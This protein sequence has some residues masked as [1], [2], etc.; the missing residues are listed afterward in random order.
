[1]TE[2]NT[3]LLRAILS[4]TARQ[5]FSVASVAE[6]VGAGEKQH[7]AFNLCDGTRTQGE[8]AK[9]AKIDRGNF[10]KSVSRWADSGILFR[11]GE[12]R[13]TKLLHVYPLPADA[14]KRTRSKK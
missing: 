5:T 7:R 2:D 6:I 9:A 14:A 8:V 10:S 4:I 3:V 13:E 12:G 1:M 11:L